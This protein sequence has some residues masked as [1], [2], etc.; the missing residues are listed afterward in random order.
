[1]T[2]EE[3]Q[4]RLRRLAERRSA[5]ASASRRR[6]PADSGSTPTPLPLDDHPGGVE[7]LGLEFRPPRRTRK[8]RRRRN[9]PATAA[10]VLATGISTAGFITMTT[11]MGPLVAAEPADGLT[12]VDLQTVS[13]NP[14]DVP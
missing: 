8:A 10:K 1:M 11:A 13:S 4:E 6:P 12:V 2:D 9:R 14:A 3:T 5:G 7:E